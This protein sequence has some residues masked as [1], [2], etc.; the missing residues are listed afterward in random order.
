MLGNHLDRFLR[1]ERGGYTVWG[2]LWFMLYV[3]V[4]GLAVDVTDAYRNQTMLQATADA[5]ALAG[6]MSP[7]DDENEVDTWAVAYAGFNMASSV[8]GEV[9]KTTEVDIGTWNFTDRE[10]SVGGANPNAVRAI[11]RRDA[12]NGNPVATNFLRI[13]GLQ[14]WNVSAVAVAAIGIDRCYNNGII[15]GAT[16]D[17]KPHTNFIDNICLI[18][19]EQFEFRKNDTSFEE[20]VYVGAGCYEEEKKC[21]GPGNQVYDNDDFARAFE[22]GEDD[23]GG[24]YEVDLRPKDALNVV[25]YIAAVQNLAFDPDVL[26]NFANFADFLGEYNTNFVDY[27]GYNYLSPNYAEDADGNIVSGGVPDYAPMTGDEFT[28]DMLDDDGL[29]PYTVYDLKCPMDGYEMPAGDYTNVAVI[30]NC[31]ISFATGIAYNLTNSMIASTYSNPGRAAIK[32]ASGV[33][34]GTADTDC[35]DWSEMYSL[36]DINFASGGNFPNLRILADGDIHFAA[37]S[38]SHS[39]TNI[40]ATGDVF[41]AS[42]ANNEADGSTYGYCSNSGGI[43]AKVLTAALVQ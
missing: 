37:S 13:I 20:G 14:T 22:M 40:Q 24:N 3:G 15:A 39:G 43:G 36:G 21:I 2:L 30:S 38:D 25:G 41:M 34:L 27:S 26:D 5:A 32:G 11:T 18:G 8:H 33:N 35:V 28:A 9:L 1:D 42:G 7:L 29:K 19:V 4:G 23:T 17:V 6:I 16:L 12:T 10:F 31:P